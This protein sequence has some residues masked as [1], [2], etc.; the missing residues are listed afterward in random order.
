VPDPNDVDYISEE[1]ILRYRRKCD[2]DEDLDV[3]VDDLGLFCD[4]WLWVACWKESAMY[5]FDM[6][7]MGGGESMMMT[8][9]T[10]AFESAIVEEEALR[11]PVE[12]EQ[13][14]A[15]ILAFL[16]V[17]EQDYPNPEKLKQFREYLIDEVVILRSQ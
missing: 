5:R 3:D 12:L 10:V 4:E 7:A 8:G 6:M 15:E 13:T 16:E 14:I 9:P 17:I 11:D 2:F 1:T